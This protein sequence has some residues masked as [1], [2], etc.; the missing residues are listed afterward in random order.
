MSNISGSD[1]YADTIALN[2]GVRKVTWPDGYLSTL[3]LPVASLVAGTTC[4]IGCGK[5]VFGGFPTL[6]GLI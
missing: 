6:R 3:H 4:R 5:G 1:Q 2:A